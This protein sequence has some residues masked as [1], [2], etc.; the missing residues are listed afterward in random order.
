MKTARL[1]VGDSDHDANMLYAVGIFVPDPFI[2]FEVAGKKHIVVSDLEIDR[3][4]A[5]ATVDLVLPL[6]RYKAHRLEEAL[7]LVLREHRVRAVEVP[8]NFPVGLAK[9]LRGIRV[10]VKPDPFI[11]ARL[12]KTAVEVR[13]LTAFFFQAEDGI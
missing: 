10:A 4:K 2:Y 11:A 13:K 1:M 8:M 7:P 3:A 9:R 6:R 5:Q 12:V